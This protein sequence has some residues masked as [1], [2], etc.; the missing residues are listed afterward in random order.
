MDE[1]NGSASSV[2][3]F[4]EENYS[5]ASNQILMKAKSKELENIND[6]IK[7]VIPKRLL[8]NDPINVS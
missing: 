6:S 7:P 2:E 3:V 8:T 5:L 4:G 1:R